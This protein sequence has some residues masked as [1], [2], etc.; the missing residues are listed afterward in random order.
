MFREPKV[1]K[2]KATEKK[3]D[4]CAP[5]RSSIRRQRSVRYNHRDYHSSHR[6]RSHR[7]DRP[8]VDALRARERAR[9]AATR[10][11]AERALSI[12]MAA[13]QAHA[14]ASRQRRLES[15]R[16][17]L[18]DALSYEHPRRAINMRPDDLYSPSIMRPPTPSASSYRNPPRRSRH[19]P[20]VPGTRSEGPISRPRAELTRTPPPAYVPSPPYT[21]SGLSNR[22]S[23]DVWHSVHPAASLT[24]RFAPA[25]VS[26]QFDPVPE[27]GRL[28]HHQPDLEDVSATDSMLDEFPPLRRVSR[29]YTSSRPQGSNSAHGVVD[30][31]GDRW[32]SVSPE[33]DPWEILLSTMPPDERLPSTSTSSFNSND[34]SIPY[35]GLRSATEAM[36]SGI[37]PYPM[38]CDNT[39]SEITEAEDDAIVEVLGLAGADHADVD[40][41]HMEDPSTS[42]QR[43]GRAQDN[44]GPRLAMQQRASSV[45]V[46]SSR[47]QSRFDP[48]PMSSERFNSSRP[49]RE[50]L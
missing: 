28:Q 25:H 19:R 43:G 11:N 23:P 34:D 32:R 36:G 29:R 24:P 1:A 14:E 37:N 49:S 44:V 12:E 3:E 26:A 7:H 21:S 35:E 6:P 45:D 47:V 17:I 50:R 41:R 38:I 4:P 16:A 2:L 31:L 10:S 22:S 40:E 46:R 8:L 39:D 15:G 42:A 20:V 48:M 33:N 30:G 18:R 27:Q 13:D 5:A 9:V